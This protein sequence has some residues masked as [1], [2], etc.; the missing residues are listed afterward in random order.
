M[1]GCGDVPMVVGYDKNGDPITDY[2]PAV[3][4]YTIDANSGSVGQPG[5]YV[6]A[7]GEIG[8]QVN[9]GVLAAYGTQFFGTYDNMTYYRVGNRC[10]KPC[11]LCGGY[12]WAFKV[13][14]NAQSTPA[15][16][17]DSI[18]FGSHPHMAPGTLYRVD[19]ST[20]KEIWSQRLKAEIGC[21]PTVAKDG[22]VYVTTYGYYERLSGLYA[23]DAL[24]GDIEWYKETP[25]SSST[26]A[27]APFDD[28][29]VYIAGGGGEGLVVNPDNFVACYDARDGSEVWYDDKSNFEYWIKDK[30]S[31]YDNGIGHWTNSPGVS[32]DKKVFVGKP[33]SEGVT[34]Y[35]GLFCLDALTGEERWHSK[36]GYGGSTVAIANGRVYTTGKGKVY[37]FGSEGRADLVPQNI[38]THPPIFE[39]I[40]TVIDVTVGN[41]GVEDAGGFN[42]SLSDSDVGIDKKKFVTS[43][44][45]GA[46]TTVSFMWTP[47][48][49]GDYTLQAVVNPDRSV[50][51]NLFNNNLSRDV[52]VYPMLPDME[53]TGID[54]ADTMYLDKK[55]SIT[56]SIRNNGSEF[57]SYFNVRFRVYDNELNIIKEEN[58]QPISGLSN[59]QTENILFTWTPTD[60][61]DYTLE[62]FA[63][64]IT[65]DLP[66][67][68]VEEMDDETNN[69]MTKDIEVKKEEEEEPELP[70]LP[71]PKPGW[72]FGPGGGGGTGG[73]FGGGIG[74]GTGTG[75]ESGTGGE[76]EINAS[77]SL[78]E[79]IKNVIGHPFGTGGSKGGGGGGSLYL[80]LI[81][82]FLLLITFFYLGYYKEKRAHAKEVSPGAYRRDRNKK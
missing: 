67:G 49:A 22:N 63:D 57:Y 31:E 44:A 69:K 61:G 21:S 60:T 9:G 56:A 75:N 66:R 16:G 80:Y 28:G 39:G 13:E 26:P 8:C 37:A 27:H 4:L 59:M 68:N 46:N 45:K 30:N 23:V 1:L 52:T 19:Q 74:T 17:Y 76:T 64:P 38:T 24:E 54:A 62:V 79:T 20:G 71:K 43:L 14:G 70:E 15:A 5:R 73:G 82:L 7:H 18:Y 12:D 11:G 33:M 47:L 10:P 42:V 48:A 72:P 6:V 25:P 78:V 50:N 3:A 77:S 36:K 65:D 32:V 40:E 35:K 29:Y 34:D 81:L 41:I 55:Y 53:V 58:S 2:F 51:E